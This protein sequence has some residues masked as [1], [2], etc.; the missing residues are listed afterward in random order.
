MSDGL[1]SALLPSLAPLLFTA[2]QDSGFWGRELSRQVYVALAILELFTY[3]L[4]S[5]S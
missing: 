1:S 4:N 2:G 3:S 5:V